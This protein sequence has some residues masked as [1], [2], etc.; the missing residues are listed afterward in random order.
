[1]ILTA[2]KMPPNWTDIRVP[3]T[4]LFNSGG[5]HS[6]GGARW[7]KKRVQVLRIF[8]RGG[9]KN[10]DGAKKWKFSRGWKILKAFRLFQVAN[11]PMRT[12]GNPT[13]ATPAANMKTKMRITL[14]MNNVMLSHNWWWLIVRIDVILSH[15][16]DDDIDKWSSL[17]LILTM[18]IMILMKTKMILTMIIMILMKTKM[19][20]TIAQDART[21]G[22]TPASRSFT[23]APTWNQKDKDIIYVIYPLDNVLIY[24]IYNASGIESFV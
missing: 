14:G 23:R 22:T 16:Y 19:I 8:S 11:S 24:L 9:C 4:R 21:S 18:I 3:E 2:M 20:L 1:M 6:A 15:N 10:N 5:N 7:C 13:T 12:Q 17:I